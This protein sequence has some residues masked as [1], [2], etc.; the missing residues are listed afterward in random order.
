M[1]KRSK[2]WLTEYSMLNLLY[3]LS[4][5][6]NTLTHTHLLIKYTHTFILIKNMVTKASGTLKKYAKHKLYRQ[7]P[8]H[9]LKKEEGGEEMRKN[10]SYEIHYSRPVFFFL[11]FNKTIV[12]HSLC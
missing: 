7:C 5:K 11:N 12:W 6:K 10:A 2:S 1:L 4:Y 9:T 8:Y 3:C